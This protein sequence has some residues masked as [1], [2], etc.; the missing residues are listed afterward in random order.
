V[1][2]LISEIADRLEIVIVPVWISRDHK[3]LAAADFLSRE[4]GRSIQP[5]WT[6]PHDT[7]EFLCRRF[8][9]RPHIDLFASATNKR[10]DNYRSRAPE[11]GS[12]GDA[13]GAPWPATDAY[14]FPPFSQLTR[15]LAAFRNGKGS[16]RGSRLLLIAPSTQEDMLSDRVLIVQKHRLSN[17]RLLDHAGVLAPWPCP[18]ELT[19]FCILAR[20]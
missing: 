1:L 16:V 15:A 6:L 5:E 19:A 17:L 4:L 13:F 11:P 8:S 14:A 12:S 10:C 9:I 2:R 7:Y 3:W 20:R 18:T